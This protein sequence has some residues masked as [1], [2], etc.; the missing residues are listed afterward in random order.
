M[1]ARL[2]Q[3]ALLTATLA[4]CGAPQDSAGDAA[5]APQE[6]AEQMPPPLVGT[7]DATAEQCAQAMTGSRLV[8]AP[9]TLHFYYG[10]ATV[11]GVTPQPD[12]YYVQA[13]LYHLES[14]P[15]VVPRPTAYQAEPLPGGGLRLKENDPGQ[16]GVTLVRCD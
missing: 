5:P 12:G 7:Y 1:P 6:T 15:E 16:A 2:F 3:A 4:A 9:D 14:V 10:Y 13:V 8:V 11:E